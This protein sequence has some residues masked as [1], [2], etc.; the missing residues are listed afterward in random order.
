M[1][2][3]EKLEARM[4]APCGINCLACSVHIWT[5]KSHVPA[6]ERRLKKSLEKVAGIVSK[7][8]CL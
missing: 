1:R 6:A 2:M 3:P 7:T 4:I 8:M 5:A